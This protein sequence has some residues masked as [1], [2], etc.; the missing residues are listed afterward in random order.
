VVLQQKLPLNLPNPLLPPHLLNP[1]LPLNNLP[2]KRLA[3]PKDL[4]PL[5]KADGAPARTSSSSRA[6]LL[7]VLSQL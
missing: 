4:L 2:L 1:L 6:A 7:A 5:L 3:R